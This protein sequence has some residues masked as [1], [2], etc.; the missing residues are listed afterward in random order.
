METFGF[1]VHPMDINDVTKKYKIANKINPKVVASVLKRRRPFVISEITGIKSITGKEA[2][3]WFIIVP[4]LPHQF[5]DLDQDYVIEK[6]AK[7]C[8]IG[9]KE[10][11][12]IIGLGAFTAIPGDGGRVVD[13]LSKV[14]ITTGNTY[15][16]ATAIEGAVEAASRM[17][18]DISAA[19]LAVVGATGSIGSAATQVLADRVGEVVLI[20]RDQKKLTNLSEQVKAKNK[21]VKTSTSVSSIRSADIIITVTGAANTVIDPDDVKPGAVICDV[22]RPRDV[23]ELVV[24]RR[25]DVLVIDGGIVKVPGQVDIH[26]LTGLPKGTALACMAETMMLA[27]EGKYESYSIGKDISLDK[28]NETLAFAKKHGFKLAGL[29]S[30]EKKLSD[31][32]INKV[33]ENAGIKMAAIR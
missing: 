12:G 22:A 9:R 11:A 15:T 3:G 1:L 6:I 26:A 17:E 10:G 2:M 21:H 23:A 19:T 14:P 29:R 30:F 27:L 4:F 13:N 25:K 32:H 8:E 18:I 5:Y 7:A 28:V 20:G 16:V 31:A 24:K 33:R